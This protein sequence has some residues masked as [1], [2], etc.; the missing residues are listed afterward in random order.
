MVEGI[1][2]LPGV[3]LTLGP[4]SAFCKLS[5]KGQQTMLNTELGE[6]SPL[7]T[8]LLERAKV[9]AV[10]VRYFMHLCMNC[11]CLLKEKQGTLVDQV[12]LH[13]L[14]PATPL[15][16][17]EVLEVL[18]NLFQGNRLHDYRQV[19]THLTT[20]RQQHVQEQAEPS[21]SQAVELASFT[22]V[23]SEYSSRTLKLT[24]NEASGSGLLYVFSL[25]VCKLLQEA[26]LLALQV[27]PQ[28]CVAEGQTFTSNLCL[29]QLLK[30]ASLRLRVLVLWDYKPR[31]PGALEDVTAWHFSETLLQAYY[32]RRK[33]S[34]PVL[35]CLTDLLEFHYFFIEGDGQRTLK[36]VKYVYSLTLRLGISPAASRMHMATLLVASISVV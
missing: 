14:A 27:D 26:P 8:L 23:F 24:S 6:A 18:G 35:H 31:V 36:V 19:L 20:K 17:L 34:Y 11:F 22:T 13:E 30:E 28:F 21:E 12:H 16:D 32:L 2:E 3:L 7:K 33:H 25:F 10:Q 5:D 29:L 1:A 9:S 4:L 15:T